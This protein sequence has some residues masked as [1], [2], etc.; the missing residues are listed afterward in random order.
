MHKFEKY[1]KK[2]C[3][4]VFDQHFSFKYFSKNCLGREISSKM[5]GGFGHSR[6]DQVN[7]LSG[8]SI[9]LESF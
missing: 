9:V 2:S 1:L 3:L 4:C 6:H 5:S 8:D 7:Y